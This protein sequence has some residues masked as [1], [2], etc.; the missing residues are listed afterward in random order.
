VNTTAPVAP[1]SPAVAALV[2]A[3]GTVGD[4]LA[5]YA[6]GAPCRALVPI[7]GRPMLAYVLDA[8]RDGMAKAG[9]GGRILVAGDHVPPQ[10][11]CVSVPS[12]ASLVDTLLSG[13]SALEPH[14]T[15]LLVVTADIPFLTGAAVADFVRRAEDVQPAAFVYPIVEAARCRERFPEMKRTTLRVAEGEYTGGNLAMLDPSFLRERRDVIRAAYERR[16]S[17]LRLAQMLG[18]PLIVR[19]LLSRLNPA[20]LPIPVLEREVGRLLGGATARAVVSP[21]AEVGTDVDRG[22]D[23][24]IARKLL[25]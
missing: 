19:L 15:R 12:G 6:E 13:A 20:V 23:I 14:E 11:G 5:A 4:D 8:L 7:N 10:D 17:K 24:E 16:K 25:K 1:P 18:A 21:F 9:G 22:E 3:G 2:L